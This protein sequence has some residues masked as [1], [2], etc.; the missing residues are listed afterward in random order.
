MIRI[1]CIDDSVR[2]RCRG[3]DRRKVGKRAENWQH[4]QRF[5]L[6]SAFLRA[7]KPQHF[8]P[9]RDKLCSDRPTNVSGSTCDEDSHTMAIALDTSW[10]TLAHHVVLISRTN[11][12]PDQF[13]SLNGNSMVAFEGTRATILGKG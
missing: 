3:F 6:G 1:C 2:T 8:M 10:R 12:S 9:G 5:Q 11:A 13:W 4:P 7:H